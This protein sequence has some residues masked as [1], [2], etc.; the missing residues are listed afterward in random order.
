MGNILTR[1]SDKMAHPQEEAEKGLNTTSQQTKPNRGTKS[2]Q[3]LKSKFF[4]PKRGKGST[5]LAEAPKSSPCQKHL[6]L[7]HISKTSQKVKQPEQKRM[8]M[9]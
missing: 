9:R 1:P 6:S 7:K 5:Q 3:T 8:Y 4:Y 2:A